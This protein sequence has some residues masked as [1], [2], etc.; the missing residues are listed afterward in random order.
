MSNL[1]AWR[2]SHVNFYNKYLLLTEYTD[3]QAGREAECAV[4]REVLFR[5]KGPYF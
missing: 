3:K 5:V 1:V 4:T 2:D